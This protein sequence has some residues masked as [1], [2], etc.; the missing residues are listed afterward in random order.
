MMKR[1]PLWLIAVAIALAAAVTGARARQHS[2]SVPPPDKQEHLQGEKS[3]GE[4]PDAPA[5]DHGHGQGQMHGDQ[6]HKWFAPGD[7]AARPNPVAA[8]NRSVE[9]GRELYFENCV[10][11][12]GEARDGNGPM[13]SSLSTSPADLEKMAPMH[14]DGDFAWKIA[15]GRGDMPAWGEILGEAEIWDLVNY[16]KSVS[17]AAGSKHEETGH[18]D[19]EHHD[20][21]DAGGGRNGHHIESD[22]EDQPHDHNHDH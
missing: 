1:S 17:Q 13:A 14:P 16:L 21:A 4:H 8:T 7:A 22:D 2:G 19:D 6:G 15:Q 20:G 12:H 9:R 3:P 18:A 10:A 5:T 11:C